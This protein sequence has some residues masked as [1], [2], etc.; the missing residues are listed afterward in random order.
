M[1]ILNGKLE[2]SEVDNNDIKS[3]LPEGMDISIEINDEGGLTAVCKLSESFDV[4]QKVEP[5]LVPFCAALKHRFPDMTISSCVNV[6][7][8]RNQHDLES[9]CRR[10]NCF[11]LTN[12]GEEAL[13]EVNKAKEIYQG[14][15]EGDKWLES[16][17]LVKEPTVKTITR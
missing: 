8:D 11:M 1:K 14:L 10:F 5:W 7:M 13:H 16:I 9:F 6:S 17:G 3:L 15:A 4:S 12:W 2:L